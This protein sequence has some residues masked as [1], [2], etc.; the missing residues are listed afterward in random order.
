[1]LRVFVTPALSDWAVTAELGTSYHNLWLA[2][3]SAATAFAQGFVKLK[4]EQYGGDKYVSRHAAGT[5]LGPVRILISGD[6][7]R[8]W[9]NYV[10]QA[11]GQGPPQ[12]INHLPHCRF[13]PIKDRSAKGIATPAP[14][15]LLIR[16]HFA[17]PFRLLCIAQDIARRTRHTPSR[18]LDVLASLKPILEPCITALISLWSRVPDKLRLK[19]YHGLAFLGDRWYEPTCS[20][21]VQKLPFGLYL[22]TQSLDDHKAAINEYGALKTVRRHIP[23]S[24]VAIPRPLD[25]V[26]DDK[27]SYLLTSAVPGNLVGRSFDTMTDEEVTI[28]AQDLREWL[29]QLRAIPRTVAPGDHQIANAVGQDCYDYRL[30]S[31][32]PYDPERGDYI[33]PFADEDAL[34]EMMRCGALPDVVHQGGHE[35]V[36][37][38]G[39]LNLRNVL[40]KDGKLSGIVYWATAGWYPEYW[41]YTKAHLVTKH[42]WRWKKMLDKVF[43]ELGDYREEL[44]TE[45]ELW[46]YCY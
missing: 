42:H 14:Q 43:A 5:T 32:V 3:K 7:Y 16:S 4:F 41:D 36:F 18:W 38:H 39:D 6:Q 23:N 46:E 29:I 28:L 9:A 12:I 26:A 44:K 31:A 20:L 8:V 27:I 37:T 21:H 15:A 11:I 24:S 19:A 17:E 25:L 2:R 22:K 40:V 45:K 1:M 10:G 33:G 13:A 35:I 30:T 34:I